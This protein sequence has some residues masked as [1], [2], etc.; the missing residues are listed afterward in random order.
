M[1]FLL[2]F[3]SFLFIQGTYCQTEVLSFSRLN[4]DEFYIRLNTETNK[5]ILDVR[6]YKDFR[7]EHI[8]ESISVDDRNTLFKLTDTL[9]FE[10]FLFVYCDD[11][12]RSLEVCHILQEQGFQNIYMLNGGIPEWKKRKFELSG[13]KFRFKKR[14]L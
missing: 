6:P 5:L 14:N 7:K 12:S 10:I 1:R 13:K 3:L 2:V 9:D 8:P 4:I 11:Y